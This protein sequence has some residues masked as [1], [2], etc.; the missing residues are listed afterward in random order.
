MLCDANSVDLQN[1]NIVTISNLSIQY[2]TTKLYLENNLISR[3]SANE[4]PDLPYLT[5]LYL[6]HNL[7][8][9]IADSAFLRVGN[10][11]HL[12]ISS[13]Q[14]ISIGNMTFYGLQSVT[15]LN[16]AYNDISVIS[17]SAFSWMPQLEVLYLRNNQIETLA[18]QTFHNLGQLLTINLAYNKIS[19]INGGTFGPLE[20][21]TG[22]YLGRN[23]IKT[24][25]S[26]MLMGLSNLLEL[27]FIQN[28]VDNIEFFSFI[29]TKKLQV[30][31]LDNNKLSDVSLCNMTFY[32]LGQ[33]TYLN[34]NSNDL[35]DLQSGVFSLLNNLTK[36]RL[37]WGRFITMKAKYFVGL[38]KL[39]H[40][41]MGESQ[42]LRE[43]EDFAF[44][45]LKN[46]HFL[47]FWI[48]DIEIIGK[49]E[50]KGLVNLEQF[51]PGNG[52]LRLI[53][54]E[55]FSDLGNLQRL[56]VERTELET[57]SE[58]VFNLTN[59][60]TVDTV[61]MEGA[62]W[63]CDRRL[64]WMMGNNKFQIDDDPLC[65]GP[66]H[67]AGRALKAL[68]QDEL[69]CNTTCKLGCVRKNFFQE[70]PSDQ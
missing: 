57:L 8:K 40:L 70:Y 68:T 19:I 9:E 22:L 13:N 11:T 50:L 63:R 42:N 64:C 56:R 7:V 59:Y 2:D 24:V 14:L 20:N 44:A 52:P 5:H 41:D 58:N 23:Q 36:L 49:N 55:A 4:M 33:L 46:L 6:S 17:D 34:L 61:E 60:P 32:G 38:E 3:L 15:F 16:L 54:K 47:S 48:N 18:N 39:E 30:L 35:S 51:M 62:K 10:L 28:L 43:I 67:L 25:Q 69:C 1:N 27:S 12:D 31:R 45:N 37:K 66:P 26:Q 21:L 65:V 53:E 29:W